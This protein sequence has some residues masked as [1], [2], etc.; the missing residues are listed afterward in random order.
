MPTGPGF[1]G[2]SAFGSPDLFAASS[3]PSEEIFV[4]QAKSLEP[5][6]TRGRILHTMDGSDRGEGE[7]T[8]R[9]KSVWKVGELAERTSL[10]VRTLHHYDEIGLLSPSGRTE[11]GHRLYSAEDVLRLQQIRS[12]KALGFS[13]EEIRECLEGSS[14]SVERLI[15]LHIWGLKEHIRLRQ[16]LLRRLEVLRGR[17]RSVN[18]VSPEELAKMAMEVI[19]VSERLEKYYT[20]EQREYLDR[21]RQQIGEGS[22]RAAEAEWSELMEQVRAE[23]V[24][25][26]DPADERV[27]RLA[28]RWMELVE[29]FTGGDAGVARSVGKMW[30]QEE[31]IHGID[32]GEMREMMS[33]ICRAMAAPKRTE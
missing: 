16:E 5:H 32:T 7:S 22:I 33:Y 31:A 14:F 1:F 27:Q 23:M 28:R 4:L 18:E 15:E 17:L 19:E 30:Q 11:A 12:L 9:Q 8:L 29:E 20:P 26:T 13:L 24:A 21:R 25:G 10:S 2:A 6:A 3:A